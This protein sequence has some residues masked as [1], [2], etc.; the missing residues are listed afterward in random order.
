ML[1]QR[2]DAIRPFLVE[3][4]R[5]STVLFGIVDC[6]EDKRARRGDEE[7]ASGK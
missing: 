3:P 5:D 7:E 2:R 1:T 4:P 6:A